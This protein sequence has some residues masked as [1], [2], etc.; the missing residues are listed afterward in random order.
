MATGSSKVAS[1]QPLPDSP[2]NVTVPMFAPLF[3][4]SVPVWVPVL[5]DVL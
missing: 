5:P 4:Q 3:D 2:V 1:C